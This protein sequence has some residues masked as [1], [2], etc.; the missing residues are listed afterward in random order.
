M[1]AADL[2]HVN[3]RLAGWSEDVVKF[4]QELVRIP[5]PSGGESAIALLVADRMRVLGIPD[6]LVD[7]AGNVVGR[8]RG[9][10]PGK[11]V[12]LA[13]H[14]DTA[15]PGD[16]TLWERPP[17]SGDLTNGFVHGLGAAG[18]KGAI[19]AQI[20]AAAALID[21]G[22]GDVIVASVVHSERAECLG[23]QYLLD[24][25]LPEMGVRPHF[26]I[27]GDPT[28]LDLYLGH[29]G[30]VELEITTI[31]RTAHS[32]APWLGLNAAYKMI[33]VLEGLEELA[34]ALPSH[35]FLEKSTIAVTH[36]ATKPEDS[37]LI[38][39]RCTVRVD[40]RYLPAESLDAVVS[41]LQSILN[42]VADKDP[43]FRGEAV[44]R[45]VEERTYSG[46]AR[47]VPK[48]MAAWLTREDHPTVM[49]AQ[50]ALLAL[51]QTPDQGKWYFGTDGSYAA[52]TLG[53]PTI[54]YSPG[55]ERYSHTPFDRVS[56]TNVLLAAAGTAAIAK[57][58]AEDSDV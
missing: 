12:L 32:S 44:I 37:P 2:Q 54:G 30:R 50:D 58:V 7:G 43:E 48:V 6:V 35:P 11:A 23:F 29:R 41:Q 4:A 9:A 33:P 14:L 3:A 17:Y 40:R 24:R 36:L 25:T 10:K 57:S 55:E 15:G 53:L 46:L 51:G 18:N 47:S 27:M 1:P 52:G 22:A 39:D 38:P 13:T 16:F 21:L 28:G 34:T 42:R 20:Y 8:I 5:S 45:T 49:R 26:V 31:G 56:T 19:S